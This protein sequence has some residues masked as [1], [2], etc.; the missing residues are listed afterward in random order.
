MRKRSIITIVIM[1]V[2]IAFSCHKDEQLPCYECTTT[3][4]VDLMAA[5]A[6]TNIIFEGYPDTTITVEFKC[7]M[8]EDDVWSYEHP[9]YG[10]LSLIIPSSTVPG[11]IQLIS[12][13]S[14][15]C[16]IKNVK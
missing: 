4:I 7:N 16:V 2:V 14:T 1:I 10:Q 6:D 9:G 12:T 13:S 15:S 3:R 5:R 11:G 8:S